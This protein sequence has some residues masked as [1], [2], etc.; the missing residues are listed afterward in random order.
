MK[1]LYLIRQWNLS[2]TD[3]VSVKEGP[4]LERPF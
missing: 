2:G 1:G 4:V 3:N